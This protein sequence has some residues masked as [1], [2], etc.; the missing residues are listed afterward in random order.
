MTG[1]SSSKEGVVVKEKKIRE[2]PIL[3]PS[4][5][6]KHGELGAR[7][8][9][10][11]MELIGANAE[12]Q[13]RELAFFSRYSAELVE[14]AIR[15][16]L[17]KADTTGFVKGTATGYC[18]KVLTNKAETQRA[19]HRRPGASVAEIEAQEQA[20]RERRRAEQAERRRRLAAVWRA[21]DSDIQAEIESRAEKETEPIRAMLP[22]VAKRQAIRAAVMRIVEQEHGEQA[23]PPREAADRGG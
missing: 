7:L 12:I 10:Q 14:E 4:V 19:G 23:E 17:T 3:P 16:T 22:G 8:V 15:A 21:L 2:V 5:Y 6:N 13:D 18:H 11:W 9:A 1:T 20:E